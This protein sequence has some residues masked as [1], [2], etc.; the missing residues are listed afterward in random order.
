MWR[1]WHLNSTQSPWRCNK[2]LTLNVKWWALLN[3]VEVFHSFY[4]LGRYSDFPGFTTVLTHKRQNWLKRMSNGDAGRVTPLSSKV[5]VTL[6]VLV[7]ADFFLY[8]TQECKLRI[9]LVLNISKMWVVCLWME[10]NLIL[11]L[12][13]VRESVTRNRFPALSNNLKWWWGCY[14]LLPA[15]T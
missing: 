9:M 12:C 4:A 2:A 5:K 3:V 8:F 13:Q 15:K 7:Y 1:K 11:L 14:I 10:K 6:E